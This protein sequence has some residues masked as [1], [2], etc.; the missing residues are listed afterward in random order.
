MSLSRREIEREVLKAIK[1][2]SK[3]LKMLYD[4]HNENGEYL[5]TLKNFVKKLFREEN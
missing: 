2:E 4:K 5:L 1:I 3:E